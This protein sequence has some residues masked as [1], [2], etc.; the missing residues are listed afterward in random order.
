[1]TDLFSYPKN[2]MSLYLHGQSK[3]TI[4]YPTHLIDQTIINMEIG[5]RNLSHE[6]YGY[7]D[8]I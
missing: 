6:T 8:I 1:M 7:R 4:F 5:I 3:K 2:R